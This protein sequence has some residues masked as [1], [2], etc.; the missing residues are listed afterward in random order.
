MEST[1][2]IS[3]KNGEWY[4]VEIIEKCEPPIHNKKQDL[5]RVKTWMNHHL[6]KAKSGEEAYDK[7]IKIG[8]EGEFK[9]KNSD[10]LELEWSFVGIGDIIPIYEDNIEDGTEIMWTDYGNIS[11]RRAERM[12]RNK[13]ELIE[14][15]KPK[16][17]N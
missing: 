2:K 16:K 12:A 8:K 9:F 14:F 1:D 11:N 6:I 5:R 10:N 4:I 13:K 3:N 15:I 17:N 7:A